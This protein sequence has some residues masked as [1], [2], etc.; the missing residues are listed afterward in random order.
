MASSILPLGEPSSPQLPPEVWRADEMNLCRA[1]R[2]V[3]R[4]KDLGD[5]EVRQGVHGYA[6]GIR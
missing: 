6:D 5:H 2:S 4:I 3:Y 1:H